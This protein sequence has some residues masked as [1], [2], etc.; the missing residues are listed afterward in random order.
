MVLRIRSPVMLMC[1]W[2]KQSFLLFVY[3]VATAAC[4]QV[5]GAS[6]PHLNWLVIPAKTF[7]HA[8]VILDSSAA[9][10]VLFFSIYLKNIL[11]LE[12]A[13]SKISLSGQL[14][15]YVHLVTL[16]FHVV[17]WLQTC[18]RCRYNFT[19]LLARH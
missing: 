8:L 1:V 14:Y 4:H 18:C 17:M 11:P 2:W 10:M 3:A 7:Q 12:A 6:Q 13:S 5:L 16:W 15:I 9:Q 19:Y